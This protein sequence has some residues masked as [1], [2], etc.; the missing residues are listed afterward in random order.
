M[1]VI[2]VGVGGF[3][4]AIARY[5]VGRWVMGTSGGVF[6]LGTLVVNGSGALLMGV[7]VAV[8]AGRATTD[9]TR[10]LLVVGFLGGYTTLSAFAR[11]TIGLMEDGRWSAA[12]AYL[13]LT[14]GIGLLAC[15]TGLAIGRSWLQ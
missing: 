13:A 14:N 3:A 11:E 6:P 15:A 8:L 5:V 1:D 7:I 2:W 9:P 12:V 10:L 4:G